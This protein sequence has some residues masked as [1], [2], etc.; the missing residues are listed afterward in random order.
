MKKL[1]LVLIIFLFYQTGF[2]QS[3]QANSFNPYSEEFNISKELKI[4]PNPT[5][6]QKVTIEFAAHE[7][8][9]ITL[10]NIAGKE[11]FKE[12]FTFPENKKEIRLDEISNGI[13]LI[14]IKT[15]D[16]NLVVKKLMV[17]AQ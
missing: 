5:N 14:R 15:T 6:I 8:A 11:V 3:N 13:Y 2:S 16:N 1:I 10:T 12:S 4:Y 9:E 7:I 17:S